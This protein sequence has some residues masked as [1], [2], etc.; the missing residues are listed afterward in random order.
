MVLQEVE[1]EESPAV[2]VLVGKNGTRVPKII[3]GVKREKGTN[4]ISHYIEEKTYKA[5]KGEEPK[6]WRYE[7][8]YR[9]NDQLI[10]MTSD[11]YDELIA[12]RAKIADARKEYR[13]FVK[14]YINLQWENT[15]G[16]FE[17]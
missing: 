17:Q 6:T 2:L 15:Y 8:R 14:S 1:C 7:I 4:R 16:D 9:P 13:D 10:V 5:R 3:Q 12:M 11:A